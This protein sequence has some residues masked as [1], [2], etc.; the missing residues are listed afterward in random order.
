VILAMTKPVEEREF[1][2]GWS[3]WRRSHQAVAR[4]CHTAS[5]ASK[6]SPFREQ[7]EMSDAP[8]PATTT[9]ASVRTPTSA[10]LTEQ[11]WELVR[12][13]MPPQKPPRGRPRRDQRQVL[14]GVLWI[15][16]TGS[17]WRDLPEEE[18]GPWQTIYGQYR[19]WLKEGLWSRIVEVLRR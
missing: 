3:L 13:L 18:F 16:D 1:R 17:S 10:W 2:L 12:P 4:R 15:M 9:R 5:R 19:K 6:R 7:S 11:K 8:A 14:C